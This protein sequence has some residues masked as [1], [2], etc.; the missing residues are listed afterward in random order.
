MKREKACIVCRIPFTGAAQKKSCTRSCA[1]KIQPHRIKG[2]RYGSKRPKG[3]CRICAKDQELTI[4]HIV[5]RFVGGTDNPENLEVLC[6]P[7]NSAEYQRI[8][9]EAMRF[10]FEHPEGYQNK[11]KP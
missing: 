2:Y 6:M 5:P 3:K 8:V 11:N 10:Y 7:C 4:N 1:R 9:K